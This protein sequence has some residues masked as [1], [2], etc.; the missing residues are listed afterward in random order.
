LLCFLTNVVYQQFQYTCFIPIYSPRTQWIS[1]VS[2]STVILFHLFSYVLFI[3]HRCCFALSC[4]FRIA[5]AFA[6]F[7]V[8]CLWVLGNIL[9]LFPFIHRELKS[10]GKIQIR[11]MTTNT[12][13]IWN[14]Q[15]QQWW[16]RKKEKIAFYLPFCILGK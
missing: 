11:N 9:V 14:R 12:L 7:P 1:V 2:D 5:M 8:V 15:D 13:A 3:S 4:L 16:E 10:K 6:L